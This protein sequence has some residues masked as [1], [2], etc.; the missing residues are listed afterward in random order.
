MAYWGLIGMRGAAL[1]NQL[2]GSWMCSAW[3]RSTCYIHSSSRWP[4]PFYHCHCLSFYVRAEHT[5]YLMFAADDDD[6]DEGATGTP[7]VV[8]LYPPVSAP[9]SSL[10]LSPCFIQAETH[11]EA[12]ACP[13]PARDPAESRPERNGDAEKGSSHP[14]GSLAWAPP[15]TG[16]PRRFISLAISR[17][18]Y[19][20]LA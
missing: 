17:V 2:L 9:T 1:L 18:L 19:F 20:S 5:P 11:L 15:A 4:S 13:A 14:I 10:S 7:K 6:D 16:A 12:C 8:L 3:G